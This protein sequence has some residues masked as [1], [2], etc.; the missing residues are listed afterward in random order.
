MR[1]ILLATA[2]VHTTAAACDY[3]ENR[4]G[5]DDTVVV[6]TV[7]EP[8]VTGRDAADAANVAGVRL[9]EPA[10][11]T[12]LREGEPAAVIRE[13]TGAEDVDEVIV[14]TVR[15]DPTLAGDPPGSTVRALLADPPAPTVVVSP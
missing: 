1:R 5:V 2:S 7:E 6:L 14:G 11:E 4:L 13:V 10:V 8:G 9:V 3:L 15:G 12:R